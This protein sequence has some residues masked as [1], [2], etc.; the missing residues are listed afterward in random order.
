MKT[1]PLIAAAAAALI[2][3]PALADRAPTAQE[4]VA[5]EKVLR[6]NGFVSWEEIEL[7]DDGPRWEVDDARGKDNVRW[8]IKIDPKTMK[9]VKRERD[10]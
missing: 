8:D 3:S 5:V 4:R 10:D 6:A 2:G 7:D 1:T 9:I